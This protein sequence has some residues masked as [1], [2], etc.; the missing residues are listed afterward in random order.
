MTL[1]PT[2]TFH[3]EFNTVEAPGLIVATKIT[4]E[5]VF[6]RQS[7]SQTFRVDLSEHPLYAKL[8][9]YVKNNPPRQR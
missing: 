4:I 6:L 1:S 5:K 3:I 9:D 2:N 8:A 7:E